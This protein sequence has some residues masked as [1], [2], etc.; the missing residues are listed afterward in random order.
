MQWGAKNGTNLL[1]NTE[2]IK[3]YRNMND[4]T[5]FDFEVCGD[6]PDARL[7]YEE[8]KRLLSRQSDGNQN[9]EPTSL[10]NFT[11]SYYLI[12]NLN[13]TKGIMERFQLSSLSKAEGLSAYYTDTLSTFKLNTNSPELSFYRARFSRDGLIK[14]LDVLKQYVFNNVTMK[15]FYDYYN[16]HK[17]NSPCTNYFK[18]SSLQICN[19][20]ILSLDRYEGVILWVLAYYK[21][22][23]PVPGEFDAKK[24]IISLM[25]TTGHFSFDACVQ[26]SDLDIKLKE[27]QFNFTKFFGCFEAP[28][29]RK[30]LAELQYYKSMPTNIANLNDTA[31]QLYPSLNVDHTY[32]G[33]VCGYV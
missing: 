33:Q 27:I 10:L 8:A 26:G 3:G 13:N 16:N 25:N 32:E 21:D 29:D 14:S 11:N 31:N 19:H 4:S 28:C 22:F 30:F 23:Q 15:A 18:T 6:N 20:N 1:A 24:Y 2:F 7:T 12:K 17:G 5:L 9:N